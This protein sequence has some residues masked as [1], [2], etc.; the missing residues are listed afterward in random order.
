MWKASGRLKI[1]KV[2]QTKDNRSTLSSFYLSDYSSYPLPGLPFHSEE[3][4]KQL[5]LETGPPETGLLQVK[6][7]T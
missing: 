7:Q 5:P 6:S 2:P 3:T 4:I 1:Q